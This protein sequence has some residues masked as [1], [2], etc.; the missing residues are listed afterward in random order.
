MADGLKIVVGADVQEAIKAMKDL[1]KESGS[2]A[3]VIGKNLSSSLAPA[4]AGLGKVEAAAARL[5]ATIPKT[6]AAFARVTPNIRSA[7]TALVGLTRVVQDAPFGFIAIQN[8]ITELPNLFRQLRAET[9][10]TAGAFKALASS[11]FGIGG[12]GFAISAI[13]SALTFFSLSS[14]GAKKDTD[15]MSDAAKAAAAKQ[16]EF[17]D[18][19][20]NAA[21]SVVGQAKDL[22]DLRDILISANTE[23]TRLADSTIKLGLAQF[24]FDQKNVEI[25]KILNAEIQRRLELLKQQGK[26]VGTFQTTLP[27]TTTQTITLPDGR[28]ITL[29][30]KRLGEVNKTI[31]ESNFELSKLAS[32]GEGLESLFT[33]IIDGSGKSKESFA[34]LIRQAKF[35]ESQFVFATPFTK[36]DTDAEELKKARQIIQDFFSKPVIF[37]IPFI[38]LLSEPEKAA[39][40]AATKFVD[41]FAKE[42]KNLTSQPGRVDFTIADAII[43]EKKLKAQRD[44]LAAAFS[45]DISESPLTKL[46]KQAVFAAKSINNVLAPAFSDLFGAILQ[47]ENPIKAFFTSLGQSVTQLI[48]KLIAAAIQAAILSAIFPGGF[49]TGANAVKGFGSIFK[50]ILGFAQGGIVSGPTLALIGEGVGTSRSNPEVVAPLDQLRAMLGDIGGG[51]AHVVVTGKLRGNDMALQNARTSKR[52]RRTT[53]R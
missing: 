14:R 16:K 43:N 33:K 51:A 9:G 28:M 21:A 46:Q 24:I 38:P 30:N 45:I 12:I 39:E 2:A 44:A 23:T 25:Q 32:L 19:I 17:A 3:S 13:T 48:Q 35:L 8:N 37:K 6:S 49:G 29:G 22:K 31:N 11:L 4:T 18:A 7:N 34:D 50:N 36:L 40:E 26:G 47:G 42:V 5:N 10:S 53:G 41:F 15:E 52:Q 20:D 1:T 27:T